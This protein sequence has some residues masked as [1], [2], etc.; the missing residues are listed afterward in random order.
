MHPPLS[1]PPSTQRTI[2]PAKASPVWTGE[3]LADPH[4]APDKD[5]R[6]REM[7]TAIAPSYDLNNRLHSFGRD[8]S[9][10][11]QTVR[12]AKLKAA[13]VV[14]D[15][16][17]G[18]GDLTI[19]FARAL[20]KLG[21]AG[22][23]L[24][25]DYTHAMLPI[26]RDKAEASSLDSRVVFVQ[27]DALALPLD[28]SSCDVISIAF[29]LRNV[30]DAPAALREFRRVLR[31]GGRLLVLEFCTPSNPLIRFANDLYTKRIM[32]LT[33]TFVAR[34]TSGA[35]KYLPKSV[36]SFYDQPQMLSA[37]EDAGFADRKAHPMTFG[38]CACYV[39]HVT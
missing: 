3:N 16:A 19:A 24:G 37:M 15:V 6:V 12:L 5:A 25:V 30:Q 9:W 22:P 34:D 20:Q 11:K 7:F 32:P 26:A 14:V 1:S 27:A 39:G 18:T 23:V 8:Q 35:Y 33:A 13:D 28:D 21:S 36:E 10:R 2:P 29:G 31:P 38:V 17:C 4:A